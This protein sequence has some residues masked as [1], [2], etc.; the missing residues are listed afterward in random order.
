MI[1]ITIIVSVLVGLLI[2][3]GSIW[4]SVAGKISSQVLGV[5]VFGAIGAE[6]L[7]AGGVTAW[8]RFRFGQRAESAWGEVVTD[9]ASQYRNSY[10]QWVTS[11]APRVRFVT[12]QGQA[13]E[14]IGPVTS[15]FKLYEKG[16][17]VE[18]LYLPKEPQNARIRRFDMVWLVAAVLFVLGGVFGGIAWRVFDN[19]ENA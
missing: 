6:C 10:G 4:L 7:G 14:F 12:A 18:V 1:L 9:G 3:G 15:N 19:K 8:D 11:H 16:A 13:V 17:Q 2:L 5:L